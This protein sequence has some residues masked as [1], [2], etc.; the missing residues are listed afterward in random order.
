MNFRKKGGGHSNPKNFVADFS[1]SRKKAQHSFPK[2]GWVGVG[3]VRGRLE[4]FRKFIEFGRRPL[5]VRIV[6]ENNIS[7]AGLPCRQLL[8]VLFGLDMEVRR[9][10]GVRGTT[11]ELVHNMR[12]LLALSL[13]REKV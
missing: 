3:G 8:A 1:I 5:I 6:G 11:L 10:G 2:I 12:S 13:L 7:S 9:P 4:V